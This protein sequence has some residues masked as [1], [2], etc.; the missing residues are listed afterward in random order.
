VVCS[1]F[2]HS[3]NFGQISDKN[4]LVAVRRR[5]FLRM[6]IPITT[7]GSAAAKITHSHQLAPP[8][9]DGSAK[10]NADKHKSYLFTG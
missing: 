6:A 2:N 1:T 7:D 5:E 4:Y 3:T 10:P 8:P 9:N